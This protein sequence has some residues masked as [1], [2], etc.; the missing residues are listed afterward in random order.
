MSGVLSPF[1]GFLPLT[2]GTVTG[3]LTVTGNITENGH[4]QYGGTTPG[5]AAGGQAGG[6]PPAPVLVTGSNDGAGQ[7][8]FGTGTTPVAGTMVA[9]TFNTA[10]VIP[11]GGAPHIVIT[12]SNAVTQALG[13]Y[14]SG[15]SPVG[16]NLSCANAPAASQANSTYSF[17]YVVMG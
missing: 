5:V 8:T 4:L 17:A 7:I 3:A 10:W 1:T 15:L 14:V 12:P 16:F 6:S 2:G 13:I 9:V 11:G